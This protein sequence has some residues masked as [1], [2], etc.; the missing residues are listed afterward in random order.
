MPIVSEH[1]FSAFG[2]N[3]KIVRVNYTGLAD[4]FLVDQSASAVATIEPASNAPSVS[5]GAA[6]ANFEKTVT[7]ASGSPDA[8]VTVVIAHEG[9]TIPSSKPASRS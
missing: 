6:D 7:L 4:T 1:A 8:V 9:G 5:I 3:Y 2:R